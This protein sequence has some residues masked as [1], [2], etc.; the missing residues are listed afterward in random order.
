MPES[1]KEQEILAVHQ[2]FW[3]SY[4]WRDLD[5]RFAVCTDDISFIGTGLHERALNKEEYRAINEKGLKDYPDPFTIEFV[6]K[7]LVVYGDVAWVE[8]EVIWNLILENKPYKEL[9]M[10]TTILVFKEG[11]WQVKHVHGSVPDYRFK[12]GEYMTNERFVTRNLELEKQVFERTQ[13]LTQTLE[14]LKATQTQLIQSE[15]MASLGELTAGIAHEIQNPLNFVNNFSEVNI[16]LVDELKEQLAIGNV[17]EAN[18]LADGIRENEQK[19]NEHGNR[20]DG[21]V[22]SMLQHS[23][24]TTDKKELADINSLADEYMRLAYHGWRAKDK[25][26]NSKYEIHFDPSVGKMNIVRQ[27]IGRVVL[28][29]LNNAFYAVNKKNKDLLAENPDAAYDPAV[30]IRTRK[31][32]DKVDILITDNGN[33]IPQKVLDKI[34]QPFFTTKPAGEGTGLGLSLSYDLVKAH[35]GDLKVET[36]ESEGTTFIIVLPIR[37]SL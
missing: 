18:K 7:K 19:I 30:T 28:N 10:N 5:A 25:T 34:F 12:E 17:Q 8:T 14:D 13:E 24:L 21:I 4:S 36:K 26:F 31:N 16:E 27:D 29:L 37:P 33:G 11:R 15:K 35:G 2:L 22:K 9:I 6:W 20:A 23:R 3:D 1:N 32:G